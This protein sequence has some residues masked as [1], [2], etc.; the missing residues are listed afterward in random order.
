MTPARE[1]ASFSHFL[2]SAFRFL[3]SGIRRYSR[4]LR[5]YGGR[6]SIL[7]DCEK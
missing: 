6:A 4:D 7:V 3:V 2:P 1:Y 5:G